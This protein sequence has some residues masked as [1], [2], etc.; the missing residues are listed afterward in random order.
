MRLPKDETEAEAMIRYAVDGG[1]NY[2]DT[3]YVYQASEEII[4]RALRGG[5]REKVVLATKSPLW[6]IEDH[7]ELE[8]CLDQQ[9]KRLRTDHVDVYL[10]HNLYPSNLK[11]AKFFDAFGFL[12]DMI[13]KGKIRYK[14]FSIHNTFE[15]FRDIAEDYYWD[16]AQI[17]LNIL[18]EDQQ[19]GL[20]G[21]RYGAALGLAMV[22]MEPLR[23]GTLITDAPPAVKELID[24]HAG[25]HSLAEWC[26]KWLYDK[27]EASV[28]LSGAS[29]LG[30]LQENLRIFNDT[31]PGSLSAQDRE[32]LEQIKV[33]Y[34]AAY[35]VGCTG[36]GYCMP[37]A[38]GVDIPQI[39]KTYNHYLLCGQKSPIDCVYYQKSLAQGGK[40]ADRCIACG[41]CEQNCSQSLPITTLLKTAHQTLRASLSD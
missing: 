40:G 39:L 31:A 16:M 24:A 35:Q 38:Q 18:D 19:V 28:I 11:R 36:C 1:I 14:G 5:Y 25:K 23:G 21:L 13:D 37:C 26:F 9:L 22:I 7:A 6:H 20:R 4:G 33:A 32:F 41:T 3:A 17:Q 8:K 15:A 2:L 30:Q 29:T 12:D 34:Q 27:A 10:L